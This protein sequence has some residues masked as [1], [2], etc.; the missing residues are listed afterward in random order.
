MESHLDDL[1]LVESI[2]SGSTHHFVILVERHQNRI[3]QFA[4]AL[5]RNRQDAEDVAQEVFIGA[6]RKLHS[7]EGRSSFFTW[8]RRLAY[9]ASIDHLR[10]QKSRKSD[11][12]TPDVSYLDASPSE[13]PVSQLVERETVDA[14]RSA[15][16]QLPE[17]QRAI[18]CMRDIDGMD[19]AE[20]AS[21]LEIPIGT[22]RS[23]LHRARLELKNIFERAGLRAFMPCQEKDNR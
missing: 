1:E 7:F 14:V 20:I 19:Y 16:D 22:V 5:L 10:K 12:S 17:D 4:L 15:I 13:N 18:V 21:V 3:F 8:L 9:N 6:F 2:R 11:L 23:R